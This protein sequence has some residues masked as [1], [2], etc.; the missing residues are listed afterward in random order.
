MIVL[1]G[2]TVKLS[3]G[4]VGEVTEVW[5][6]ARTSIRILPKDSKPILAFESDVT[7]IVKRPK[8]SPRE[9]R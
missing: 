8:K 4:E 7:E 1:K 2:D 6:A 3:S 9:R 5:G